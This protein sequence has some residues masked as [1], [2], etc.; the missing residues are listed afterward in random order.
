MSTQAREK[1]LTEKGLEYTKEVKLKALQGAW[2]SLKSSSEEMRCL[3]SEN[4]TVERAKEKY[5]VW[6]GMYENFRACN[7]EYCELLDEGGKVLHVDNFYD[8][9]DTYLINVKSKV[10][11]WFASKSGESKARPGSQAGSQAGSKAGSKSSIGSKASS[12]KE[13]E[14]AKE[15]ELLQRTKWLKEKQALEMKL[16]QLELEMA[17]QAESHEMEKLLAESR[18]RSQVL[19]EIEMDEDSQEENSQ[20]LDDEEHEV[21]SISSKKSD[22]ELLNKGDAEPKKSEQHDDEKLGEVLK[23]L[24][25]PKLEIKKFSGDCMGFNKFMRQFKSRIEG[26]CSNDERIAYLEKYTTGEAHQIVV[27]FSYLDAAVGYPA[28]IKELK[29]RYGDPEVIANSYVKKVFSWPPI[30]A[31]DPK[32][33]DEFA[34]FL[35]ECEAAT[36]CVGGLGVLEFSE[37]LKHILQKLPFY[38]HD[39]WRNIVQRLRGKGKRIGFSDLVEFIQTEAIKLNDP[40][41]GRKNL[42]PDKRGRHDHGKAKVAAVTNTNVADK[43]LR[44]WNCGESHFFANCPKLEGMTLSE[45]RDKVKGL[46]LCFKCLKKGHLSTAC[47]STSDGCEICKRNHHTLL[48][49]FT[50]GQQLTS[51]T[52]ASSSADQSVCA[53]AASSSRC[54]MP[55][56]PVRVSRGATGSGRKTLLKMKT[57]GVP[58]SVSTRIISGLKIEAVRGNGVKVDLPPVFTKSSLPVDEWH[59]P[60]E[61][62][63][64]GWEH[65]KTLE[66]PRLDD[67]HKIDLLIGNNVPAAYAPTEVKTGP[68]GSPFATKTPLGWVAWGVRRSGHG[69]ISSNFTQVDRNLEL[70]TL[71]RQSLN[72]DF[73]EKV[74]DDKR[75]WSWEDKQ[76]M[77]IMDSSCQMVGGHFQVNLPLRDQHV[78]LPNNKQMAMKRL[79][80]L[81]NKIEKQPKFG[82]DYTA[83]MED[84]ITK[85]YAET[86]P[87]AQPDD[88][89][90]WYVPHHGVY[91]PMKPEKIRVVFDCAARYGGMSLND[92]LLSGPNL[93]NSLQGVL[94]RFREHP[95]AFS[96]DI[97]CMF[98]QVKVPE[99]QRDLLRFLW[100]PKGDITGEPQSYRMT[101]H[102]FGAVSS[103]ACAIYSLRKTG[104]DNLCGVSMEAVNTLLDNFYMD[105]GLKSVESVPDAIKLVRELKMLCKRGGFNLT[106]WSSNQR[107][108]LQEIPMEDRAKGLRDLDLDSSQLPTERTLGVL[109][110]A[111]RDVFQ[112]K[113]QISDT[114]ATRRMMLSVISSIYDPLG[115]IAPL[116]IPAKSILQEMCRL[117]VG[118][119]DKPEDEVLRRWELWKTNIEDLKCVK[120]PRCYV[121][122]D[123]GKI[124]STELH[125]FADASEVGYG[126]VIYLRQ[127]SADGEINCSFVFAKARVNPLKRITIPR[128]ELTAATLAVRMSAIVQRELDVKVDRVIYWTD[129]TAVLRYIS[130]DKARFHTFVANRIQVIREA[131]SASQWH[132]V[133]TKMNPADLASRGVKTAKIFNDSIWLWGPKF[134]WETE[135]EWPRQIVSF[136]ME[137]NDPEV[138][139]SCAALG[140]DEPTITDVLVA[141]IS[142][143]W[144]LRRVMAWVILAKK[145]FLTLIDKK[146]G[147]G[148]ICG[149]TPKMLEESEITIVRDVQRKAYPEEFDALSKGNIVT[150]KSPLFKLAP[151]LTTKGVIRVGGRLSKADLPYD[152]RHPL[153]LPKSSQ[154]TVMIVRDAHSAVGHLG[155]NS[156]LARLREKFWIHG[157]SQLAKAVARSCVLCR[158]YQAKP[159]EQLMA[160]L[161]ANRVEAELSPFT[162]CGMDYFGPLMVRRGRSDVKRYGVIFTCLS[163][164]AVHLEVAQSL[165]T[166][167]CINAVRRFMARRGPVKSIK[168]DNGT[169]LVGAEKELRQMLEK[170]DQTRMIDTFCSGGIEWSFNPPAG[171]HFGGVWERMIRTTRKI[172]YSLMKEQPRTLD[173]DLLSTL[174]CEVENILNNRPLTTTSPDPDDLTPLTPNMLVNP[175]AK[176][177][178]PPGEFEQ[179]DVYARKR[180][181]RAQYLVDVF[182]SRWRKE[183]V[184][185]LQ[186]RDK[187]QRQRRNVQVGDV[188]LIV[189]KSVPRNTWPMGVVET[190]FK[191]TKGDVRSCQVRTKTSILERPV[192]KLCILIEAQAC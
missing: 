24:Q 88:G 43:S 87:E 192:A 109:W 54:T 181:R 52:Q 154:V 64:E 125:A 94:M 77:K 160:D 74:V 65:L 89:K 69:I 179:R 14:R 62:D 30:R 57:M 112:F 67:V 59:I 66:L 180:W 167:A 101:V 165:E 27:G 170:V 13:A 172:L 129:S 106:K 63:V 110:D 76:F 186:Q 175:Q 42:V 169:N 53:N 126:C 127:I 140:M 71:V 60:T 145:K 161:P 44:C 81:R 155:R 150:R 134:L 33:L 98:Y 29:R 55:I 183:Y 185:T 146:E 92:K 123:F 174:L 156:I 45:R 32:A 37:N 46:K 3:I 121:P 61:R 143:W 7:D 78:K 113:S 10:E 104:T 49:D 22:R 26:L 117:S 41:Y 151:L 35:K 5:G 48:H 34:V 73:P 178:A 115:F 93:M 111:E 21:T 20:C 99:D 107:E 79:T 18:G 191:D 12:L 68:L 82:A 177:L 139:V 56:I 120:I 119:D 176:M 75:E 108:V 188:V 137:M 162:H 8:E 90:E 58:C 187:W 171:S 158:C 85:G 128:L 84:V 152:T 118:W 149:L 31:E 122:A 25:K 136:N 6:M 15:E 159:C 163:S 70:E 28:A 147:V 135:S 131:S 182:W 144:V 142:S 189:D 103:P 40:V 164:R 47:Q 166:D 83:F 1:V 141:R 72:Y 23:E 97:E 11:V 157:G 39:R 16:K 19:G 9:K 100:W 80:N 116:L 190:T 36:K 138:K 114:A 95:V 2:K 168:S 153:V 86:V 184:V 51:N 50:R 4:P 38:M 91:H 132:Y 133:E 105:D 102:L 96:S 124:T 173:D 148:G 17:H 130:N